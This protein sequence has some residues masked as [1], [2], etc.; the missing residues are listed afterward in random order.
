MRSPA[1]VLLLSG[2]RDPVTPPADARLVAQGFPN[3][4]LILIPHGA[5]ANEGGCV[6]GLITRFVEHGAA[7]DLDPSCLKAA[8]P[9]PFALKLP[10]EK[11]TP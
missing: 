9:L 4:R 11:A 5:H 2:E 6:A 8:P 1:P 7:R 3:G 10:E